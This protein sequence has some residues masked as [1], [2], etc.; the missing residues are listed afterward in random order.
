MQSV[1]TMPY[2][3]SAPER[4]VVKHHWVGVIV[5]SA[6]ALLIALAGTVMYVTARS[7]ARDV[8]A[9]LRSVR[10]DLAGARA[11]LDHVSGQLVTTKATL[12]D[13]RSDLRTEQNV[14]QSLARCS[15][16]MFGAWFDTLAFTYDM[17]GRRFQSA[18][19]STAC[20]LPRTAYR[21]SSA[22]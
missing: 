3:P 10:S 4:V 1:P 15:Q 5:A 16:R 22:G 12:S 21:R 14:A 13:T 2:A 8:A 20:E 17:T 19:Y 7:D 11:D 18:V 6:I 9:E